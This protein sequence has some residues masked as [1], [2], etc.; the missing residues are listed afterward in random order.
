MATHNAASLIAFHGVYAKT[1][2]MPVTHSQNQIQANLSPRLRELVRLSV[3]ILGDVL[4]RELGARAFQRIENLRSEMAEL[5][6][7]PAALVRRSLTRHLRA[8]SGLTPRQRLDLA[9]AFALMLE[10]MNACENAYR[11]Q[12]IRKRMRFDTGTGPDSILYVLTAHPTEARSPENIWIFHQILQQLTLILDKSRLAFSQAERLSLA[13]DLEIA[14]RLP[15][16]RGRKPK[17]RNEAEHIYSILLNNETLV[18]LLECGRNLAPV[19]VRSWVGGDKDGHPG[20][21]EKTFRES[22]NLSR[23]GLLKFLEWRMKDVLLTL[24]NL[25]AHGMESRL[26]TLLKSA[27][28]L[29]KLGPGDGRRVSRFRQD[30]RLFMRDYERQYGSLHASLIDLKSLL[31]VFPA[32]VVPLEF[33]E[34][35]DVLLSSPTGRG[36][37]IYRMLKSLHQISKGGHPRWYVRG[38]IVSMTENLSHLQVAADLVRRAMGSVKLPVIPLFEQFAALQNSSK[39]VTGMLH[40]PRLSRAIKNHWDQKLEI[41]LGYSDSSKESGVL[42][43]RLEIAKAMHKLDTLCR[44]HGVLPVFFQGSGGS[45]ARGGGSIPEQ[46]AWWSPSALRNYKVTIQGEMVE[47]SLA[48]PE[49]TRGQLERIFQSASNWKEPQH[50]SLKQVPAID[51]FAARVAKT[52]QT[53]IHDPDFLRIVEHATPYPFLNLIKFGSRPNKRSQKLSVSGLRAIPW[54]LCWTQNRT[55]LPTWW[56]VGQ[57]WKQATPQERRILLREAKTHPL[58]SSFVRIVGLTLAKLEVGVFKLYLDHSGLPKEMTERF[59]RQLELERKWAVQFASQALG[60]RKL[61]PAQPWL[62]ESIH[63]RSPMIHPL[64]LLQIVAMKKREADLLRLS[65]AG[66]SSGMM[67]TG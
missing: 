49:I 22:L 18:S 66:I 24:R 45:T 55:L 38:F 20:V 63:L 67:A 26:Q 19:Y 13:H 35:S 3:A 62:A 11:S 10:L 40:D 48:N 34:S 65:V 47:R 5:R 23:Q 32:L 17:V 30:S 42:R 14:W 25:R 4:K 37:A 7:Q 8:I 2:K 29:R 44:R 6:G 28:G 56:G 9:R 39:I 61:V 31:H 64:N 50:R 60:S 33:R 36:L 12:A 52:Y 43:S 41:M 46:T 57:A 59:M 15:M 58:F 54:N 1:P 51:A 16:V 27:R 53:S 21:D